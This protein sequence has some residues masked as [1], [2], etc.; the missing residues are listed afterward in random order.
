MNRFKVFRLKH[1][2]ATERRIGFGPNVQNEMRL[3]DSE[4]NFHGPFTSPEI[5]QGFIESYG[6]PN[7]EYVILQMWSV[8]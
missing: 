6:D 4:V 3:V 2:K 5:A 8:S 1:V 7:T